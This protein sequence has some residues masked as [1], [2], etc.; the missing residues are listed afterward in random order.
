MARIMVALIAAGLVA[1]PCWGDDAGANP[2]TLIHSILTLH[3]LIRT[4]EI[5]SR[6]RATGA[7]AGVHVDGAP[8][9]DTPLSIVRRPVHV[10]TPR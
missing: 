5:T 6:R 10:G 2:E 7:G 3:E 1:V 9:D 8:A 4:G